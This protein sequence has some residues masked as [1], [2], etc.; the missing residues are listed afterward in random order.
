MSANAMFQD[1][2]CPSNKG[3]GY[4]T[5]NKLREATSWALNSDVIAW[6]ARGFRALQMLASMVLL[7]VVVAVLVDKFR[8]ISTE[9][10]ATARG[11]EQRSPL[12]PLLR[13]LIAAFEGR[14]DLRTR[15]R[16]VFLA[17]RNGT[18]G[19]GSDDGTVDRDELEAGL[20]GL[21]YEPPIQFSSKDW[22]QQVV[23]KGLCCGNGRLGEVQ[24][25][26]LL[27][28]ALRLHQV[29]SEAELDHRGSEILCTSFCSIPLN[30]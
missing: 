8:E 16:S 30:V 13:D 21:G 7:Q 9:K 29:N 6:L 24:F 15:I 19:G 14:E 25:E 1:V 4:Y 18:V 28:E 12:K 17:V 23:E 11:L 5:A 3:N 26:R 27:M 2:L 20:A 22:E 10:P